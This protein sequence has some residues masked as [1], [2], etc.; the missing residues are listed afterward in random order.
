M[1]AVLLALALLAVLGLGIFWFLR[2]NPVDSR[3]LLRPIL[4]LA[5]ASASAAC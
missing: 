4:V 1:P 2:A 5:A 3:A